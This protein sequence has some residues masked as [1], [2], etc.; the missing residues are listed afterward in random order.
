MP[1]QAD[2]VVEVVADQPDAVL[3]GVEGTLAELA[4]RRVVRV[5]HIGRQI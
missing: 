2:P 3:L 4:V 1:L 5:L